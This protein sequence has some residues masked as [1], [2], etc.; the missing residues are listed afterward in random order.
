MK[1]IT[2]ILSAFAIALLW[3][4]CKSEKSLI[5]QSAMGYLTAMGN[6]KISEAEPYATEETIENTLHAI[7]RYI[8]PNLDSNVIKKNTPATIEITDVIVVDDTTAEVA[9]VKT[10]PIQ[11]QEGKLDMVKRKDG[12]KAQVSIQIPEALKI[13]Y[14]VDK[15]ALEEKYMG[16]IKRGDPNTKPNIDAKLQQKAESKTSDEK[17]TKEN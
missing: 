9:Y 5:E 1:K 15:K 16:K 4:G 11:V 2:L 8:M 14:S 3:T 7:E 12:W 6:Y 17:T 10:T 13:E